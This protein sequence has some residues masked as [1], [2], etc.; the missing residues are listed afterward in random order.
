[1]QGVGKSFCESFVKSGNLCSFLDVLSPLKLFLQPH[2]GLN[3][4]RVFGLKCWRSPGGYR[5]NSARPWGRI[6]PPGQDCSYLSI[7]CQICQGCPLCPFCDSQDTYTWGKHSER[8]GR[9]RCSLSVPISSQAAASCSARS[10]GQHPGVLFSVPTPHMDKKQ[11]SSAFRLLCPRLI[12]WE[13][14]NT[15]HCDSSL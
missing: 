4:S 11:S 7:L 9:T 15:H 14:P 12:S 6:R 8:E 3:C 1:M 5:G 10:P 13:L 2:P